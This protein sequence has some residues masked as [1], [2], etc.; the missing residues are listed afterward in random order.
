MT[1][2][3][4]EKMKIYPFGELR[5]YDKSRHMLICARLNL[6]KDALIRCMFYSACYQE[7]T[8]K[9]TS[10]YYT[11]PKR[12]RPSPRGSMIRTRLATEAAGKYNPLTTVVGKQGQLQ[13]QGSC[14]FSFS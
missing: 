5:P 12:T 7:P 10:I 1:I 2:L 14:Q 6:V 4:S 8:I 9:R 3:V 13:E 11:G